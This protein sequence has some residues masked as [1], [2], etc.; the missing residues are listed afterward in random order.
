[1][2][3]VNAATGDANVRRRSLNFAVSQGSVLGPLLNVLLTN[4]LYDYVANA[5]SHTITGVVQCQCAS[6]N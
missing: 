2:S 6:P 3:S 1:M 4:S 5:F